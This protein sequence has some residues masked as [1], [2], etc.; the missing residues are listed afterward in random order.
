MQLSSARASA[1][2]RLTTP[3]PTQR[4]RIATGS[5]T[6]WA[7][8]YGLRKTPLPIVIPTM[9]A[10][11]PQNPITRCRSSRAGC[12][13]VTSTC[14]HHRIGGC[15]R[16]GGRVAARVADIEYATMALLFQP[17]SRAVPLLVFAVLG[18]GGVVSAVQGQ[19]PAPAPPG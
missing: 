15:E 18:A 13:V 14:G 10:K 8:V 11:P 17:G 16:T 9:R 2:H 7:S 3:K 5:P 1:P 12:V 4:A 19:A 6:S